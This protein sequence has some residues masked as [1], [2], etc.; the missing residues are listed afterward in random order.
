M[1]KQN[2][3]AKNI[4]VEIVLLNDGKDNVYLVLHEVGE[5][6]QE[7]GKLPRGEVKEGESIEHAA[8]RTLYEQ[9]KIQVKDLFYVRYYEL[10][11]VYH[12]VFTTIIKDEMEN[13][14]VLIEDLEGLDLA[15]EILTSIEDSL[16][17]LENSDFN[18]NIDE[19]TKDIIAKIAKNRSEIH[20]KKGWHHHLIVSN[21]IIGATGTSIGLNILNY[22]DLDEYDKLKE[23]AY[24]TL[25]DLQLSDGSWG[26]HSSD[27]KIGI[28]ESTCH[29]VNAIL[30]YKNKVTEHIEKAKNWLIENMLTDYSWGCNKDSKIGRIT[31]SCLAIETLLNIDPS[32]YTPENEDWLTK[33]QNK[34]GG[35]GFH[36]DSTSSIA[37][38]SVVIS[39]LIKRKWGNDFETIVRARDWLEKQISKN[40]P[41]NDESDLEYVK[42]EFKTY[43][44]KYKH[45][46]IINTLL[47]LIENKGI[48]NI[49]S[50]FLYKSFC[51]ILS[52]RKENGFWKHNILSDD[53]PIWHT[54]NI[55]KLLMMLY[56]KE[57]TLNLSY[58][59]EIYNVDKIQLDLIEILTTNIDSNNIV[60]RQKFNY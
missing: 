49:P 43:R 20:G 29:C 4:V 47:I 33:C 5:K 50:N 44:I 9:I 38:T 7:F 46:S 6:T 53:Y 15:S 1:K 30:K 24:K 19:I 16:E 37:A 10:E 18:I 31:P 22:S 54:Q 27:N 34:D 48:N 11:G 25:L 45:S 23:E 12:F 52:E 28:T 55:L 42:D 21:D 14:F 56:K 58:I 17:C 3:K 8:K 26:T 39:T 40:H 2:K 59:K 36:P 57:R 51:Q 13:N 35:W 32:L 60:E 41:F